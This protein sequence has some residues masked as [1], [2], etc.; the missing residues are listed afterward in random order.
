MGSHIGFSHAVFTVLNAAKMARSGEVKALRVRAL[1]RGVHKV[2]SKCNRVRA[3]LCLGP[4]F[5]GLPSRVLRLPHAV[6]H[7]LMLFPRSAMRSLRACASCQ[8]HL[9]SA[10][11]RPLKA[12]AG[13]LIVMP[14]RVGVLCQCFARLPE[15]VKQAGMRR[16]PRP[17]F[18]IDP[19]GEGER[20]SAGIPSLSR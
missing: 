11:S 7:L 16:R 18:A 9:F 3:V 12:A 20:G 6:P 15:A 2:G 5:A 19:P 17:A 1:Q 4:C 10:C 14:R 8:S 13:E